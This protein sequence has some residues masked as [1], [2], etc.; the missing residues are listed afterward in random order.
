MAHYLTSCLSFHVFRVV[1]ND[2]SCNLSPIPTEEEEDPT[3]QVGADIGLDPFPTKVDPLFYTSKRN[4]EISPEDKA[5]L[6][7]IVDNLRQLAV[8]PSWQPSSS[9][10]HLFGCPD[11]SLPFLAGQLGAH[12]KVV[13]LYFNL[14]GNMSSSGKKV[15]K[16]L[17]EGLHLKWTVPNHPSQSSMPEYSKKLA[18]V[19]SMLTRALGSKEKALEH[20][21]GDRP[22]TVSFPNHRSTI[23]YGEFLR[24]ELAGMLEAQVI[25]R[26]EAKEPPVVVNGIRIVDEKLPKLRFCINPMYVNLFWEYSPV[27][28]EKLVDLPDIILPGD[29]AFTT[30]DK[31]GYWHVPLHPAL[32]KYLAFQVHGVL[33]CFTHLPFGVAPACMVYSTIK[34]EILRGLRGWGL[35]LVHYLDDL[36]GFQSSIERTAF[37]AASISRLLSLLGFTLNL[38]KCQ[39]QPTSCPKFLGLVIDLVGRRF[40]VPADKKEQILTLIKDLSLKCQLTDRAVASIAGKVMALAPALDLAPLMARDLLKAMD[41]S[42]GWDLSYES[43]EGFC[44]S[45]KVTAEILAKSNGRPWAHT[46]EPL[47][48]VGDASESAYSAFTP[49]GELPTPMVVPFSSSQLAELEANKFSSTVRELGAVEQVILTLNSRLLGGIAGR[50]IAYCTDSQ[51]AMHCLLAMKGNPNT[52]PVVKRV[53]LL[54]DSLGAELSIHWK[55]REDPDQQWADDLSKVRDESDWILN[56]EVFLSVLRATSLGGRQPD[57][58]AFATATNSKVPGSYFSVYDGPGCQ[59]IDALSQNWTSRGLVYAF[60]PFGLVSKVLALVAR[61]QVDCILILPA[62]SRAWSAVLANLPIK[63]SLTLPHRKDLLVPGALLP[64]KNRAPMAPHFRLRA[65]IVL[66]SF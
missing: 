32:W 8:D 46:Y 14:T 52:F 12:W 6:C 24:E 3:L 23:T 22:K 55:P 9:M 16:W 19:T 66:W 34:Q 61:Q 30:D 7:L 26:W 4:M 29:W 39:L 63:E 28:Y 54:V 33:Y 41:G 40:I 42:S 44:S 11:S 5:S 60:P 53:R 48:V 15:V 27:S 20:L 50:R 36:I 64:G 65:H 25:K 10:L 47:W 13:E 35:R 57:L 62:W 51:P 37:L 18:L 45:L 43:S 17:K 56:N 21:S 38:K 58:D 31:N 1:E 2:D 59:G 49:K